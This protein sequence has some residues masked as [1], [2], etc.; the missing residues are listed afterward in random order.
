M[1]LIFAYGSLRQ[2]E[3]QRSILGRALNGHPDDLVGFERG[4]VKIEAA[5]VD[6]E[7]ARTHHANVIKTDDHNTRI[8]G[9]V[10]EITAAELAKLDRYEAEF[11]YKRVP[12]TLASGGEAWVYV[13]SS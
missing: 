5:N 7:A 4:S 3:V 2:E 6:N 12:T 11:S 10:F 9:M 8:S 13:H 1:P